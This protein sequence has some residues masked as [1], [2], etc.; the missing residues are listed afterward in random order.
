MLG[1]QRQIEP[2][3]G[4]RLLTPRSVIEG[5]ETIGPICEVLSAQLE[6]VMRET[7][8][9]SSTF[10]GQLIAIDGE[11]VTLTDKVAR[12]VEQTRQSTEIQALVARNAQI[13]S[14]LAQA[15]H[16]R[17]TILRSL[18]GEVRGL[19]AQA[20]TLRPQSGS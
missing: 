16:S 18:V 17:D 7:E 6:H 8:A 2:R 12:L 10:V 9:A 19:D 5:L 20:G 11:V 15:V 14:E 3:D 13:V 1:E 4:G